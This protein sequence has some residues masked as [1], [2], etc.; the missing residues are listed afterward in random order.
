MKTVYRAYL[1]RDIVDECGWNWRIEVGTEYYRDKSYVLF[2]TKRNPH[3]TYKVIF[4]E[5]FDT[6]E[7]AK[8]HIIIE[9]GY[10][11]EELEDKI[12]GFR[13]LLPQHCE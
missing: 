2:S 9:L 4:R 11:A 6:F 8:E 10:V 7:D 12:Q 13:D 5:I 1:D 3:F